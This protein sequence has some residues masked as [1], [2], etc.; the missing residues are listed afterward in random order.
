MTRLRVET[1]SSNLESKGCFAIA[2]SIDLCLKALV[3]MAPDS[4]LKSVTYKLMLM[5]TLI[6]GFVVFSHY[7]AI[8]AS[9][10]IVKSN[11]QKF[12]SWEDVAKSDEDLIIIR[13]S[14]TENT[15]RSAR[16][17]SALN[18]IYHEK[19]KNHDKNLASLGLDDTISEVKTGKFL[20]YTSFDYFTSSTEYP[21]KVTDVRSV[22]LE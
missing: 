9:T 6:F 1:P 11:S 18:D 14:S 4:E 3:K 17:N 21:C 19:I 13:G 16:P 15:F 7:E 12:N 2:S 10:L 5:Y 8:F 20:A 22:E